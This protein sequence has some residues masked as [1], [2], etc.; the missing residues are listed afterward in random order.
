MWNSHGSKYPDLQTIQN[1]LDVM[2]GEELNH[3]LSSFVCEVRKTDESRYPPDTLNGIIASI[4][5]FFERERK[6]SQI[7]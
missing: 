1:S 2:S 6:A 5:H 4:Q 7:L 3:T